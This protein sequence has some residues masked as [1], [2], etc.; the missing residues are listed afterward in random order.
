MAKKKQRSKPPTKSSSLPGKLIGKLQRAD[1]FIEDERWLDA[2]EILGPL[3]KEYPTRSQVLIPLSIVYARLGNLNEYLTTCERLVQLQPDNPELRMA[4]AEAYHKTFRFALA[5]QT[6][7]YYADHWPA[8]EYAADARQWGERLAPMVTKMLADIGLVGEE[9]FELALLHEQ[10]QVLMSQAKFPAAQA[11]AEKILARKPDFIAVQNNLSQIYFIDGKVAQAITFARGVLAANPQNWHALANLT[12]F[13]FLSG[14]RDE[15]L[16]CAETLK[17]LKVSAPDFWLKKIEALSYLG[18]DQAVLAAFADFERDPE[19]ITH[20][21]EPMIYHLAA[22]ATM[23]TG[24]E[25]K[26]REFWRRAL[27]LDPSFA[28]AR[29]NVDDLKQPVGNRHAP[30]AFPLQYWLNQQAYRDLHAQ[31]G[32]TH[33]NEKAV[34]RSLNNFLAQHPEVVALLPTLLERGDPHGREF[35]YRLATLSER[36]EFHAALKDFALSASGPDNLRMQAGNFLSG[37]GLLPDAPVRFWVKGAWQEVQLLNT[38][39]HTEQQRLLSP[40]AERL[41]EKAYHCQVKGDAQGAEKYL[42]QALELEPDSTA[43]LNNLAASYAA[44]GR[45]QESRAMIQEIHERFPD[46]ITG[47][48]NYATCLIRE[49]KLAEAEELMRPLLQLRRIHLSEYTALCSGQVQLWV[50]KGDR[51]AARQWLAMLE[52]VE[53]DSHYLPTLERIIDPPKIRNLLGNLLAR[54]M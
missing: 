38:E 28:F 29:A 35:A 10:V 30:F 6:Y 15:A 21:V 16:A 8:H 25:K 42:H 3:A 53:P 20:Q 47:T 27:E 40:Q 54:R 49:K 2:L 41:V 33:H 13:L 17:P 34:Q 44:Q 19:A 14:Q 4:L 46:Y 23:R 5:L 12:R 32:R 52:Q 9:G 39:I 48:I 22:V 36:A 51:E 45:H 18:D 26:A 11:L 43:I 24:E 7:R 50:A 31:L 37:K 1:E